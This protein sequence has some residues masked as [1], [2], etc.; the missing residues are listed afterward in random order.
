MAQSNKLKIIIG[1]LL[2]CIVISVAN[3][4]T[5]PQSFYKILGAGG[6]GYKYDGDNFITKSTVTIS[7]LTIRVHRRRM[8]ACNYEYHD[9]IELD[10]PI[11]DDTIFALEKIISNAER[12]VLQNGNAGRM[13]TTVYLSSPGGQYS[14]GVKIGQ[15]FK[16]LEVNT[17]TIGKQ[18]CAS[19]CALAFL[20]GIDRRMTGP[21]ILLFHSPYIKAGDKQIYCMN[22]NVA[23]SLNSYFQEMIGNEPGKRLFA[24]TMSFCSSTDGWTINSD[25]ANLYEVTNW[26]P[27]TQPNSWDSKVRQLTVGIKD[28][29]IRLFTMA[30]STNNNN[31]NDFVAPDRKKA[32][33]DQI[34]VME[35][36][37]TWWMER[38]VFFIRIF[39]P[40]SFE[41]NQI[42][43]IVSEALCDNATAEK[44][45][46][47]YLDLSANPLSSKVGQVYTAKIPKSDGTTNYSNIRCGT[48]VEARN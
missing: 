20:G 11:N 31:I 18:V 42:K 19:S 14:T 27:E 43:F 29:S 17:I 35:R 22:K 2:S 32:S 8:K 28:G 16:K 26:H 47:I 40:T 21:S 10:G 15:M 5:P 38:G 30:I 48:I 46:T 23:Q 24:R 9:S 1:I 33:V 41:I 45:S 37:H 34:T 44:E 39:N 6:F 3:S 4:Q 25:A 12:C 13:R 36:E 7:D